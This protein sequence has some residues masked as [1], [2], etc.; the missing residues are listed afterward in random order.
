MEIF[1][2]KIFDNNNKIKRFFEK[3]K[4]ITIQNSKHF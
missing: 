1:L 2:K 4:T 3:W